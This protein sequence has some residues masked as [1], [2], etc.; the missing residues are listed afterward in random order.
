MSVAPVPPYDADA[1]AAVIGACLIDPG[2][3]QR[4]MFLSE[5]DFYIGRHQDYFAAIQAV[6]QRRDPIDYVTVTSQLE[7]SGKFQENYT[8][9]HLT[10]MIA[11]TPTAAHAD[12]Y[13]NIVKEMSV[14]RALLKLFQTAVGHCYDKQANLLE[15][16][17][18][19]MNQL[20]KLAN[21]MNGAEPFSEWLNQ[22]DDEVTKRTENPT[23]TPGL[24][25]GLAGFDRFMGGLES[26]A[27][28]LL[29]GEPFIGKTLLATQMICHIAVS[30]NV[31]VAIYESDTLW[32]TVARR[33]VSA[34]SGGGVSTEDMRRGRMNE[35]DKWEKYYEARGK[36]SAAPIYLSQR[37]DWT[38]PELHA[39]LVRLREKHGVRAFMFDYLEELK[40]KVG[41]RNDPNE[42]GEYL[43]VQ[44]NNMCADLGMAA[45]A[46]HT[47]NKS[48]ISSSTVELT[49]ASGSGK[50][51][52]KFPN[53]AFVT[54]FLGQTAAERGYPDEDKA[55]LVTVTFKKVRE[56]AI[57]DSYFHLVR[58]PGVPQFGDLQRA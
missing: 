34:Y 23:D 54:A 3:Y 18:E 31:P 44:F 30:G 2:A 46:I 56:S 1:E 19:W 41:T 13:A 10:S 48:G 42:R 21:V 49:G 52:Y 20:L 7:A 53:V 50:Y 57:R 51:I 37:R 26:G 14:R 43:A 15:K 47:M 25:T 38:I 4:V 8:N 24:P 9:L 36:V 29:C 27:P 17:G 39:D 58:L 40:D 11:A 12:G 55:N 35:G 32:Q 28:L 16:R 5:D 45:I 6:A 33:I 22:L